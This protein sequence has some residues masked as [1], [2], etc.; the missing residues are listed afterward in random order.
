MWF[1]LGR[2][3]VSD[4]DSGGFW[5]DVGVVLTSGDQ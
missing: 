4:R 1:T 3:L 2:A 5:I